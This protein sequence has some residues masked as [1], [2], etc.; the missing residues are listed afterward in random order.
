MK[1]KILV[2][3]A[4]A[5]AAANSWAGPDKIKFPHDY[6]KGVLYQTLD[7]HDN[8][9]YRELYAPADAEGLTFFVDAE[10]AKRWPAE[11]VWKARKR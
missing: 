7:R 8:K 2:S 1:F 9:Q 5:L 11:E 3:A 4:A 6:L 10:W